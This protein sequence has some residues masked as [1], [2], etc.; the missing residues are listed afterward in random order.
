[1]AARIVVAIWL[2]ASLAA[3]GGG[4]GTS[5]PT[6]G[7]LGVEPVRVFIFAGQSNMLGADATISADKVHDL[8]EVALQTDVD[9][10][11]LL[12]VGGAESYP[13]GDIR[14]HN[15]VS[16]SE[17][18]IAGLRVKGHGPEVGF[19]RA[20]GGNVAIIKFAANYHALE[21]GRSAWVA[22]GS[23]WVQWQ[24]FVDQQ[25]AAIGKPYVIAGFVWSQGID[26]GILRR[27]H[28]AYKADL[29]KIAAD[30]RAKFGV[31]PFILAREVDSQ[32]A[33]SAAMAPIRQAQV[34]VGNEPG[35]S[36]VTVDDLGPY[37]NTHHL[38]AAAQLVAGQRFASGYLG[39][40][41]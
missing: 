36:W 6:S 18:F 14:G 3:C 10:S 4:G 30:L 9:R 13:W 20:L 29:R 22:P 2:C 38:S 34:E 27:D 11:S 40:A 32:V 35:N 7:P 5:T 8:A 23:L 15:T 33:G 12:T 16:L 26:D 17:E 41:R 31:R 25:L 21:G 39:L 28:D 1:M 37:V 19:N 24:A